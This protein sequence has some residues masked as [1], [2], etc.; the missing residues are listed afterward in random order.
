MQPLPI[1]RIK[2]SIDPRLYFPPPEPKKKQICFMPRKNVEDPKQVLY[3]LRYRKKLAG[4]MIREIDKV[5][6]ARAAE[7]IRESA[8]LM[9]FGAPE[10]FGLP[11][12]EALASGTIVVG[13]HGNGGREFFTS[14]YGFPIEVGQILTYA[15]TLE[16]VLEEY[17]R[18]VTRLQEMA[19]RASEFMR[20]EYSP[21]AERK[22][23]VSS[24]RRV[25]GQ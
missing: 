3:L 22:S 21:E 1:Y 24:W 15:R 8:V 11:V 17:S 20:R 13:Y 7:I 18:D 10:G 12:A 2:Y 19:K 9:S 16:S 6:E 25:L 5:S 23:I 14:E 4:W